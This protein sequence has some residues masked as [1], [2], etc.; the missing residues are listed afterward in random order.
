ML[1]LFIIGIRKFCPVIVVLLPPLLLLSIPQYQ[2]LFFA[3]IFSIL[4]LVLPM[5]RPRRIRNIGCIFASAIAL[6]LGVNGNFFRVGVFCRGTVGKTTRGGPLL[7]M[8]RERR[9]IIIS[10]GIVLYFGCFL[11]VVVVGDAVVVGSGK[12]LLEKRDFVGVDNDDP[13]FFC[14]PGMIT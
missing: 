3:Y 14:C 12:V 4:Y 13:I 2:L 9:D 7:C 8:R 11:V 6:L 5:A 1:L 10:V